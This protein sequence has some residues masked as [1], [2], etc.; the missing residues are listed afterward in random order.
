MINIAENLKDL[1]FLTLCIKIPGK[2]LKFNI[3][4]FGI[5]ILILFFYK[6]CYEKIWPFKI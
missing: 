5:G 2:S 3:C 4:P 1:I 6:N